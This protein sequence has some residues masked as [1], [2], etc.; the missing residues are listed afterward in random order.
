MRK[1]QISRLLF[2][3]PLTF[4]AC[5]T[6]PVQYSRPP[7]AEQVLIV[8]PGHTGLVSHMRKYDDGDKFHWDDV[9]YDLNDEATRSGLIRLKFACKVNKEPYLIAEHSAALIKVQYTDDC[10]WPWCKKRVERVIDRIP[11]S[12]YQRLLNAGTVCFSWLAYP[13]GHTP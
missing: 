7:L 1:Q 12:D 5:A 8:L 6:K 9:E 10:F 2:L 13:P 11:F 4:S 3:L